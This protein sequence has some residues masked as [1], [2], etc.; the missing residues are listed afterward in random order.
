MGPIVTKISI[1][2]LFYLLFSRSVH[3]TPNAYGITDLMW[4]MSCANVRYLEN[5]D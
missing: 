2:E 3:F 4:K 5:D 1:H